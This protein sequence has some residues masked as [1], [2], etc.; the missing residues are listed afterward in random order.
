M[1]TE[2]EERY[3]N[4]TIITE[5]ENEEDSDSDDTEEACPSAYLS[6]NNKS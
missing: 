1:S 4:K 2:T 3:K 5:H 6:F